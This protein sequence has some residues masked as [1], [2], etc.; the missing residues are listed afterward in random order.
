MSLVKRSLTSIQ[1]EKY[2]IHFDKKKT[3]VFQGFG[4]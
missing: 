1:N 2:I 3:A 4:L